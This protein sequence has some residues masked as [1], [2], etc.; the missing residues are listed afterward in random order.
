MGVVLLTS[1][2]ARLCFVDIWNIL[3]HISWC[4]LLV[5]ATSSFIW[6]ILAFSVVLDVPHPLSRDSLIE[7]P[8]WAS[9]Y[10]G[11]IFF[12]PC[13]QSH[14]LPMILHCLFPMLGLLPI[15][16]CHFFWFLPIFLACLSR[17]RKVDLV[18]FY[19]FFLI[20]I[21]ILISFSFSI[22]GT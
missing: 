15:F 13:I 21:L 8:L 6:L 18:S 2:D 7:S 1:S 11:H 9:C 17:L 5:L 19:F 3:V 12:L 14:L 22:F 4:L 10:L 16:W 20:L